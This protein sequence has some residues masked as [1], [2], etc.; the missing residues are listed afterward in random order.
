MP[1]AAKNNTIANTAA[2]LLIVANA[3]VLEKF[4]N[5]Y[6]IT[7]TIL[8]TNRIL[9]KMINGNIILRFYV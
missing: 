3:L 8:A 7:N 4:P 2:T 1:L 5:T 6:P 9:I